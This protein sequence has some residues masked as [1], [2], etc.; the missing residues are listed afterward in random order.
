MLQ[1]CH[2]SDVLEKNSI[3]ADVYI[4]THKHIMLHSDLM[5]IL[6]GVVYLN[7]LPA[8]CLESNIAAHEKAV[9]IAV[10]NTTMCILM[11]V[12][13]PACLRMPLADPR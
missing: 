2:S 9:D 11:T 10:C 1:G 12:A 4:L 3:Y 13:C 8:P 5:P 6:Q 7:T